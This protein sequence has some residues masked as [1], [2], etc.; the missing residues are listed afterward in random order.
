MRNKKNRFCAKNSAK[1]NRTQM[2]ILFVILLA[3]LHNSHIHSILQYPQSLNYFG[4][5]SHCLNTDE[6]LS[7]KKNVEK[8][9]YLLTTSVHCKK[10]EHKQMSMFLDS[11]LHNIIY[12]CQQIY[13]LVRVSDPA[14]ITD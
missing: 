4:N 14:L 2:N 3:F 10:S 8:R 11:K 7:L 6:V 9:P 1:P 13:T 12:N 5:K